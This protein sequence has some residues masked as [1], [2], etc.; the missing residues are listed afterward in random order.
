MTVTFSALES[1]SGISDK[2]YSFGTL[3]QEDTSKRESIPISKEIIGAYL[4]PNLSPDYEGISF[5]LEDD[6]YLRVGLD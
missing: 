1:S 4:I 6:T 2:I 3:N 5:L